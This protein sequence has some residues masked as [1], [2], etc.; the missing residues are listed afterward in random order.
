M[1]AD[2]SSRGVM[3]GL[4]K[5]QL[6]RNTP[7]LWIGKIADKFLNRSGSDLGPD[8]DEENHVRC[9]L[10]HAGVDSDRF[11]RMFFENDGPDTGI[12]LLRQQLICSIGRAVG[13]EDDLGDSRIVEMQEVGDLVR[14]QG[15]P[16]MHSKDDADAGSNWTG[17]PI[18]GKKS[19]EQPNQDWVANVGVKDA[20][21]R[22]PEDNPH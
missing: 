18:T 6:A 14:E 1:L 19:G 10:R 21:Q 15:S 11:A 3:I 4:S 20:N 2:G 13:N 5:Y 7:N 16:I 12:V 9:C 8:V 22:K 17:G